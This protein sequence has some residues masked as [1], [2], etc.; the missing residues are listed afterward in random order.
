MT[1]TDVC[2]F[3][4]VFKRKIVVF[5]RESE[6]RALR[7]FNTAYPRCANPL[8]MLSFEGHYY[9]IKNVKGVLGVKHVCGYCYR[10]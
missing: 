8:F 1:L 7:P 5:H 9:G 2:K 3:E 10:G 6:E 4:E